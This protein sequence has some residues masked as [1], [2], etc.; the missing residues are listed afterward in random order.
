MTARTW[1]AGLVLVGVAALVACG[2]DDAAEPSAPEEPAATL[3]SPG[4]YGEPSASSV[5]ACT[6]VG[7]ED[8]TAV[9]AD[10]AP[11]G[12]PMDY[13]GGFTEC[14]WSLDEDVVLVSVLPIENFA[15][16]YLDQLNV[17][18]PVAAAE[19]GDEAVSFPGVVG[20]GRAA[21]GGATVGFTNDATGVLVAVGTDDPDEA[22]NLPLA[23]DLAVVVAGNL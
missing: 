4:I 19:L 22:A 21:G 12:V 2:D 14:E 9:F 11:D 6:L 15:S 20:I 18:G 10:G 13:G 3:A 1:Q 23:T 5:D 8:L 7:D 16:D 17:T